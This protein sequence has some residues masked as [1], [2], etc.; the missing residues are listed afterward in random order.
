MSSLI[1]QFHAEGNAARRVACRLCGY[2]H[3]RVPLARGQRAGCVRCGTMLE[4]RGRFGPHAP[5][6]FAL[7]GIILAI[8]SVTLPLITVSKIGNIRMSLVYSGA[9]ALWD[10]GMRILATWV[11]ICGTLA[12]VLLFATLGALIAARRE[13]DPAMSPRLLRAAHALEYWAMP[14]VHVLA[15][16]VA[17]IKLGT[18]VN[19]F[20]GP[21]F[22]CYT[23]MSVVLALAWRSFEFESTEPAAGAR[24]AFSA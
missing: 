4:K 13:L 7:T 8:P 15:V 11:F 3:V 19:V 12:P 2:E 18:L 24:R 16:L 20:I 10:H 6:A 17:L 5:L 14:E 21:G 1:A 9:G 23:A 22:W